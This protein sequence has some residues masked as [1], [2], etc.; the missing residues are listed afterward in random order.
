MA[1]KKEP[2][3]LDLMRKIALAAFAAVAA[4]VALPSAGVAED[5]GN[6][7]VR[8]TTA[9]HAGNVTV[10]RFAFTVLAPDCGPRVQSLLRGHVREPAGQWCFVPFIV[11]NMSGGPVTFHDSRQ[12]AYADRWR[13]ADAEVGRYL[14][15]YEGAS[16]DRWLSPMRPGEHLAGLLVF[17]IPRDSQ[18]TRLV[19]RDSWLADGVVVR[20]AEL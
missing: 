11:R 16:G 13:Q 2:V 17:D 5:A 18:I 3:M 7:V 6:A 15:S 19:L 12:R 8:T 14:N 20:V 9:S 10:G 4:A 1:I